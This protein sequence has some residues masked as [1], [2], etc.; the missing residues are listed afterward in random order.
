MGFII[1]IILWNGECYFFSMRKLRLRCQITC[2]IYSHP[3]EEKI[4][5]KSNILFDINLYFFHL[6]WNRINFT[7]RFSRC[8]G[9][10][11]I[12]D[13]ATLWFVRQVQVSFFKIFVFPQDVFQ[14][15]LAKCKMLKEYKLLILILDKLC[16]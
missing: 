2:L 15:W 13:K 11:I 16:L 5:F 12:V 10:S 9:K 4:I 6:K 7:S 3:S 8:T 1:T 14:R